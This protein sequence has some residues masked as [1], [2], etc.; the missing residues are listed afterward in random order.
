MRR[1]L[2]F[3]L[4]DTCFMAFLLAHR[5]MGEKCEVGKLISHG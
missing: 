1:K 5:T 2:V 4:S 3:L